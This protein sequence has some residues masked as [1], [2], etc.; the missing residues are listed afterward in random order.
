MEWFLKFA[1]IV[2]ASNSFT[3]PLV[4]AQAELNSA[5]TNRRLDSLEDPI[6]R[7]HPDTQDVCK[8]IYESL[9][10]TVNLYFSSDFY[11]RYRRCLMTLNS[12]GLL[13]LEQAVNTQSALGVNLTNPVFIQYVASK[14]ADNKKLIELNDLI[15]NCEVGQTIDANSLSEALD[16]PRVIICSLFEIYEAKKLGICSGGFVKTRYRAIA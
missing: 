15:E 2:G 5:A 7:L 13:T 12:H 4:Q 1:R 3:A 16:I 11:E 6:G 10:N 8:E 14:C 9:S